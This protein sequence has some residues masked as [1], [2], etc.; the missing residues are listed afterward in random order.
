M[1]L[2]RP[3]LQPTHISSL[4][5]DATGLL[6]DFLFSPR[7][8]LE[9]P[10]TLFTH[11]IKNGLSRSMPFANT[12]PAALHSAGHS[13]RWGSALALVPTTYALGKCKAVHMLHTQYMHD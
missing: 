5:S 12:G 2:V 6:D 4:D 10:V 7:R 11:P 3:T 8:Q 13:G 1:G 9:D